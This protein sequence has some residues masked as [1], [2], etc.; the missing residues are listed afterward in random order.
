M[1]TAT[2]PTNSVG[3]RAEIRWPIGRTMRGSGNPGTRIIGLLVEQVTEPVL[4]EA[5]VIT[6]QVRPPTTEVG[7]V[8]AIAQ[9]RP[10]AIEAEIAAVVAAATVSAIVL[11]PLAQTPATRVLL[12]D[13]LRAEAARGK[14]VRAVLRA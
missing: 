12:V 7:T 4:E 9:L 6:A 5:L 11:S 14:A 1:L 2:P 3:P 10:P 8:A 13:L